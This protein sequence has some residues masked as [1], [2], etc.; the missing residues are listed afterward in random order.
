[1]QKSKI[2]KTIK[3]YLIIT[4]ALVIYTLGWVV[5]L[6]PNHLV[7]GGITGVGVILY[8]A[9]GF[10]AGY[11]Y[12]IVNLILLLIAFKIIGWKFG[13]KTIYAIVLSSVL[14]EILPK[15]VAQ[16]LIQELALDNGKLVSA[17]IGGALAG[18]G[19]GMSFTQGGSTGGLDIVAQIIN[20]YRNISPGRIMLTADL[21]IIASSLLIA[22]EPTWGL[23]IARVLYGYLIIAISSYTLDIVNSGAKKSVQYFIFSSKYD[24]IAD[25]IVHQ[26]HRGVTLVSGEG[27]FTKKDV[28]ILIIVARHTDSSRI[29]HIV[30]NIDKNAFISIG[31]VSGVFGKGFEPIRY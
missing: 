7:G 27:W 30:K 22:D 12:F 6:I 4:I 10:P 2:V 13:V 8:Y 21:I 18:L 14:L 1:M 24:L 25:Q 19:I 15:V 5:F 11:T 16:D 20:K 3:E 23:K 9:T 26:V 28:K 17:L 29:T 31:N